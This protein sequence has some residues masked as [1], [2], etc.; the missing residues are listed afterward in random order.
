MQQ[1]PGRIDTQFLLVFREGLRSEMAADKFSAVSILE[2]PVFQLGNECAEPVHD[3]PCGIIR[4]EETMVCYYFRGRI[5][6]DLV[7]EFAHGIPPGDPR[8]GKPSR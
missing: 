7:K 4:I 1:R 5:L 6:R 3:L 2:N 8:C